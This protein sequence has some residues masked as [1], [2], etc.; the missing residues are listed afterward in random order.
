M[1]RQTP[2]NPARRWPG[3]LRALA[4]TVLVGALAGCASAP[5]QS[6]RLDEI[7]AAEDAATPRQGP[8]DL[9][10][11]VRVVRQER[12]IAVDAPMALEPGDEVDVGAGTVARIVFP[13]GHEVTLLPGTRIRLGSI[14]QY[15]GE[16]IV[17]A[18]GYFRVET[19]YWEAGV[20]GT[21]FKVQLT[22]D[23]AGTVSVV[24]G[25]IRLRSRAGHW[26]ETGVGAGEQA[27]LHGA[28]P[29]TKALMTKAQI[30]AIKS[31]VRPTF[32]PPA[33]RRMPQ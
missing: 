5:S 18:K 2:L 33:L 7:A 1:E 29:P 23:K 13:G 14:I 30:T 27:T 21:E 32:R 24:E 3:P 11:A 31:Q 16:L 20:E 15:I 4:L 9:Q 17:K 8:S 12:P 19:E 10:R 28:A 22:P 25:S 6:L 26:P